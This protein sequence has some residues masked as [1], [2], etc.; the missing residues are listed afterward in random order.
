MILEVT[1][2]YSAFSRKRP[3]GEAAGSTRIQVRPPHRDRYERV[4]VVSQREP[5][6]EGL[7]RQ[8]YGGVTER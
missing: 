7:G 8:D 4:R 2:R 5:A 1:L 3:K 6:F